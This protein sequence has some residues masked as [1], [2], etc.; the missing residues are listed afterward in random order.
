MLMNFIEI[1]GATDP[2]EFPVI[3]CVNP[4]TQYIVEEKLIIPEVKP[5]VEQINSVM[6][7][8]KITDFRAIVTPVGLKV[9][10]N[11][12]VKQKIIY[13]AANPVQSVH[14]AHYQKSFCTFIEIPLT[15]P[16]KMSV[17]KYLQK[18]GILLDDVIQCRTDVLIEDVSVALLDPRTIKKCT[19]L[20]IWT[21]LNPLLVTKPVYKPVYKHVSKDTCSSWVQPHC[22]YMDNHHSPITSPS[23]A[24]TLK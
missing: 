11:G 21:T 3:T 14:S 12:I 5:D 15:L 2:S 22:N 13:T 8:A 6:I 23:I 1:I 10:I 16:C 20:F 7:E 4:N 9:I 24:C 18:L 19:V 17:T